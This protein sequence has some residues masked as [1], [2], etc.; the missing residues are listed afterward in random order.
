[1]VKLTSDST[2]G[3]RDNALLALGFCGLFRRSEIVGIQ[4]EDIERH[5]DGLVILLRQSKTDQRGQGRKV[6]IPRAMRSDVCPVEII[7]QWITEL[8]KQGITNGALIRSVKKSGVIGPALSTRNVNTI[9]KSLAS[10]I[11]IDDT[12][13]SGHSLRAGGATTLAQANVELWKIQQ[14]GGW[15][16]SRMLTERYIREARLFA[17][18]AMANI[19]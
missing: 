4:L 9:L 2:I 8:N 6:A 11:G 3:K 19:W 12:L 15:K 10:K 18:N 1:M 16:D 5:D 17:D 7:N 14:L 13:V